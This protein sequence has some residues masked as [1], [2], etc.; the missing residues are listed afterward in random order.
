MSR[1]S[2]I[3]WK[4]PYAVLAIAGLLSSDC[5]GSKKTI[6]VGSKATTAQVILGE[7]VAQYLE[8][9]L[10]RPVKRS[11]GLGNTA[12]VYQAMM[13]NQIGLYPEET[14]TIQAAILKEGP[15]SDPSTTLERTRNEMRRIAQFE[16]LDP[17]GIDNGWAV[18]VSK[19]EAA[20]NKIDTLSDAAR[21]KT[22][23]KL[24]VPRQFNE[25][26]DGLAAFNQYRIPMIAMTRVA[27]LGT[28]YAALETGELTMVIGNATDGQLARHEGWKILRDD[29]KVF[30]FYQTCLMVRVDLL[31]NDP[32]IQPALAELAGKIN[33]DAIRKM[34]AAV[35]V[36]H[37]KPADVAAEFLAQA[38][39]K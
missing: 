24:G 39:L 29:K 11:L 20:K 27:D 31:A 2:S 35:A 32:K 12:E 4:G 6:V 14:G 18:V 3:G 5:G 33:N 38:G 37:K 30:G 36:D 25:R 7:I 15:S 23:W 19:E 34:D 13:N 26:T 17:L 1:K 8:Q 22:G 28:L 16:L 21:V 10:G 9:R